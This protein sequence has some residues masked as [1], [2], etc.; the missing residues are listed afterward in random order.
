MKLDAPNEGVF[1]T[2]NRPVIG[3][4]LDEILQ[5]IMCFRS[6]FGG[7]LALQIMLIEANKDYASEMARI[8]EQLSP[9]EVQL[10]TPLR[11]CAVKP[12]PPEDINTIRQAFSMF[13][14]VMTVYEAKRPEVTPLNLKET[15]R[16]RPEEAR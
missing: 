1:H 9:D 8:A 13:R 10:N 15:R 14:D 7:K 6:E 2:I 3:Y 11:P 16:R 5:G 4:S 12:L